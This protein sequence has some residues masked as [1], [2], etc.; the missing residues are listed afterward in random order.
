ME[1]II[2]KGVCLG[3]IAFKVTSFLFSV[4][5][6]TVYNLSTKKTETEKFADKLNAKFE[7]FKANDAK[8]KR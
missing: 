8:P 3:M 1:W 7:E 6:Q 2:A 5:F 4:V